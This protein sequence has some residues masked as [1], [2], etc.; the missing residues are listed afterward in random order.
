MWELNYR[1]ELRFLEQ[2]RRQEQARALVI[3]DGWRYFVHGW[4]RA[5]AAVF[6]I[7]IPTSGPRFEALSRIA[8]EARDA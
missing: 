6:E 2:A 5:I 1:G 3:E 4:T 7:E 8:A